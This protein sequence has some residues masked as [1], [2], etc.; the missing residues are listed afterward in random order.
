MA[1]IANTPTGSTS[2]TGT[3]PIKYIAWDQRRRTPATVSCRSSKRI[4]ETGLGDGP[5]AI[6]SSRSPSAGSRPMAIRAK[7]STAGASTSP[8]TSRIRS[9][10]NGESSSKQTKPDAYISGEIW[11]WAQPWLNDGD[12]FDAVMNYRFADRVPGFLRQSERRRSRRRK[13]NDAPEPDGLRLSAAVVAGA[14][15][16]VRQ[17][18]HRPLRVD[19]RQP[20]L[21]YDAANRIQDNG[22]NYNA[23]QARRRPSDA[24]Q[25]QAVAL[26]MMFRRRTHDLLRR[27]ERHVEP[28][29]SLQPPA[30]G[31]ERQGAIRRSGSEVRRRAVRVLSARDRGAPSISSQLQ[32]GFFRPVKID[33]EHGIFIFATT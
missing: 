4:A 19:V 15:E 29:R 8:A 9:G 22:P 11:D 18:R 31:V 17:P 25:K 5:E 30:D 3:E 33:D 21:A 7:A 12:Q 14:A 27:R 2:A 28:G 20:R 16:P 32:T 26:Q 1:K 23:R 10:S 24:K 13:F 6:T